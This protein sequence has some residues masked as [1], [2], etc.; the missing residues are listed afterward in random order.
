LD[1]RIR[2]RDQSRHQESYGLGDAQ[3]TVDCGM[4]APGDAAWKLDVDQ[5]TAKE[6]EEHILHSEYVS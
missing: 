4:N 3:S 6:D 1:E 2:I 5:A